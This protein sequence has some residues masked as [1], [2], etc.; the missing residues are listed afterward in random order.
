LP[1]LRTVGAMN[2]AGAIV[3][4]ADDGSAL[5]LPADGGPAQTVAPGRHRQV[6]EAAENGDLFGTATVHS[7]DPATAAVRRRCG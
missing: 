5:F 4:E 3:E 7:P 6:L 2:A 1:E